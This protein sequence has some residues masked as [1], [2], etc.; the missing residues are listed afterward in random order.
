MLIPCTYFPLESHVAHES[1]ML[2]FIWCWRDRDRIHKTVANENLMNNWLVFVIWC[3]LTPHAVT[4]QIVFFRF[5]QSAFVVVVVVRSNWYTNDV[6][7]NFDTL[8][9]IYICMYICCVTDDDV[10]HAPDDAQ[11]YASIWYWVAFRARFHLQTLNAVWIHNRH[12]VNMH[13]ILMM[14]LDVLLFSFYSSF[15]F[16]PFFIRF[17]GEGVRSPKYIQ[18]IKCRCVCVCCDWNQHSNANIAQTFIR[19]TEKKPRLK[20]KNK[21]KRVARKVDKWV[22]FSFSSSNVHELN[23]CTFSLSLSLNVCVFFFS[24]V[25][26]VCCLL[27]LICNE[28]GIYFF[29][30]RFK[31]FQLF[32]VYCCRCGFCPDY[33]TKYTWN[34]FVIRI[35]EALFIPNTR[36]SF[37]NCIEINIIANVWEKQLSTFEITRQNETTFENILFYFCLDCFWFLFVV[38]NL[39]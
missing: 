27:L 36:H 35:H 19:R 5:S 11:S 22:F 34:L 31:H 32:P 38:G 4:E 7:M 10:A 12:V 14:K 17:W 33:F 29:S 39:I 20:I 26:V 28:N 3:G 37:S 9:F 23:S 30:V 13:M 24:C 8:Q 1:N 21:A 6:M 18:S 16:L 15:F 2:P 25:V